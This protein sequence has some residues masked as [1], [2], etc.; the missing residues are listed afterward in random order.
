MIVILERPSDETYDDL[1]PIEKWLC[2]PGQSLHQTAGWNNGAADAPPP[3]T[4]I[5]P[6]PRPKV[7]YTLV[8]GQE[9]FV[10]TAE[11]LLVVT[12]GVYVGSLNPLSADLLLW[13]EITTSTIPLS[14]LRLGH[15]PA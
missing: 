4:H 5:W 3:Y 9:S 12:E 2:H 11:V 1:S 6:S 10:V 14:D 15:P 8:K 13:E 7:T